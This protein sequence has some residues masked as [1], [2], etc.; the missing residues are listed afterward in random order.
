MKVK[1]LLMIFLLFMFN[2]IA[3]SKVIDVTVSIVPQKYF[4][5]KIGGSFVDV[6]VMVLPGASPA[7]YEPKPRQM[8]QLS[9]SVVYFAVGVPF[10]SVWL[11]K[12]SS[13]NKSMTIVNTQDG[14]ERLPMAKHE[15]HDED[16]HEGEDEHHDEHGHSEGEILD[17]HIWLSPALVKVQAKTIKNTLIKVDPKN[18]NAYQSNYELFIK[19]IETIDEK[20]KLILKDMEGNKFM[21]FHPSWGYFAKE[22]GLEQIPVEVEG[23]KPS[24]K[25]LAHLIDEANEENVKVIFVQPQFSQKSAK[26]IAKQIGGRTQIANPLTYDWADNLIEIAKSFQKEMK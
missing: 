20:I 5:E 25:E 23:K 3:S 8:V 2:A 26:I 9:K 22:Y 16:E 15:H 7:T 12:I 1:F 19:E 10:E 17:P 24:P 6:N 11:D 21:V 4:V 18:K 13:I 14:I